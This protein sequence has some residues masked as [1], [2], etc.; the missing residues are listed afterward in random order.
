MEDIVKT[1]LSFFNPRRSEAQNILD[2]PQAILR[3]RRTDNG[4]GMQYVQG[5]LKSMNK[6]GDQASEME[7]Y[8]QYEAQKKKSGYYPWQAKAELDRLTPT[9]E[10]PLPTMEAMQ[11]QAEQFQGQGQSELDPSV[12]NFIEA[13][14]LPITR[15][16]GIP[17]GVA[18]GQFAAEGRLEG[19]GARR[20]NFYNINAIDSN[21]DAAY[22]YKDPQEGIKAYSEL[23]TKNQRYK[24][25]FEGKLSTSEMLDAIERAGYAGDPKTYKKR[26]SNGFG[27]YSDF[28][29]N[30]P[31]YRHYSKKK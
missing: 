4:R 9:P 2:D 13:T 11:G 19:L 31:E 26:A 3:A 30:T 25:A 14:I 22:N 29:E 23:L 7:L 18:A 24:G 10:A 20:N 6:Q 16:Y 21:P 5:K 1:L 17:D 27:S 12:Q 8:Q 28:I 15:Q